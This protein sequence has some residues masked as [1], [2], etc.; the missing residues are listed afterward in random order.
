ME[1]RPIS[2]VALHRAFAAAGI[3]SR[4]VFLPLLEGGRLRGRR[5]WPLPP[6][7]GKH[8]SIRHTGESRCPAPCFFLDSGL[9]R[10]DKSGI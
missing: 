9:R 5:R 2:R 3:L 8:W 6:A 7:P 4:G 1:S 10:N